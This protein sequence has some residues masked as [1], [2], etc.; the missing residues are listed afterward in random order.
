LGFVSV[1]LVP[2]PW[3]L[4]KYG[5]RIRARS[6]YITIKEPVLDNRNSS[7]EMTSEGEETAV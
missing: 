1:A 2:V 7:R 4:Y 6:Q 3:V 5:S